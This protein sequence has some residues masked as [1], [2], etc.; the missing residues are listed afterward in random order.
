[1]ARIAQHEHLAGKQAGIARAQRLERF[2]VERQRQILGRFHPVT[3][4]PSRP[5]PSR[6]RSFDAA[7]ESASAS[8]IVARLMAEQPILIASGNAAIWH[9]AVSTWTSSASVL[10]PRA[11]GPMPVALTTSSNSSS[12]AATRSSHERSPTGRRS[13]VFAKM[14]HLVER[15]AHADADHKRRASIRGLRAHAFHDF[16]HDALAP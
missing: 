14:R 13:A 10:P 3:S 11:P 2:A 8:S 1:M 4:L 12:N 6:Q 15:R 5:P 16:A 9:G 7:L